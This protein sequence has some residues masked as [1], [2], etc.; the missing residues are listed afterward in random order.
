ML[1]GL[2]SR[3]CT[4][5][6]RLVFL[7]ILP[8]DLPRIDTTRRKKKAVNDNVISTPVVQAVMRRDFWDY[9]DDI[10]KMLCSYGVYQ[11]IYNQAFMFN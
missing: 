8:M 3:R 9:A 4:I 6:K 2:V 11:K 5:G 7:D 1:E 10:N